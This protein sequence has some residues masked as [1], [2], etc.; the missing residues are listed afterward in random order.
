MKRHPPAII[1]ERDL[2]VLLDVYKHRYLSVSQIQRLRFPSLQTTYRRLR[3]LTAAGQ[4]VGFTAHG[5]TEH[6]Y[7]LG[8]PGLELVAARLGVDPEAARTHAGTQAPK[9]YYFL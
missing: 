3:V 4:L 2:E 1:T 6:M 8:K 7:F 5:L 9:D